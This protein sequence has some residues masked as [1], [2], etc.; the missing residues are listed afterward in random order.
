LI[1]PRRPA[2]LVLA[3]GNDILG[4]DAVGL[5]AARRLAATLPTGVEV[6]EAPSG[7]LALLEL[8]EGRER[9]LIL[10]AILTGRYPAGTVLEFS[11]ADLEK[12]AAPS[13]HFAGLPEILRLVDVLAIPFPRDLRVLAMEVADPYEVREGLTPLV[14]RALPSLVKRAREV[15]GGW[16][17]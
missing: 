15:V 2:P 6:V 4:D 7:G 17:A 14:E 16:G 9:A 11:A 3:L 10:D 5:L 1:E 8:L 12:V 13:P